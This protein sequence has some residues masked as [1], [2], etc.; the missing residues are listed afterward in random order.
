MFRIAYSPSIPA[1]GKDWG[2]LTE[3]EETLL[4][5]GFLTE[6]EAK[7]AASGLDASFVSRGFSPGW[8]VLPIP[9]NILHHYNK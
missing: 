7:T 5:R 6:E 1:K 9:E 4:W 8:E 3:E 2:D